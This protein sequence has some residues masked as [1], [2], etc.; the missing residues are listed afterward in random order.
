MGL[1]ARNGDTGL[2]QAVAPALPARRHYRI[3]AHEA[4][5]HQ[6]GIEQSHKPPNW[7]GEATL[8][9]PPAHEAA[10]LQGLN[11]EGYLGCQHIGGGLPWFEAAG[12]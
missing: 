2:M 4:Y 5:W 9:L 1:G 8:P 11:P 7:P 6:L 3:T 12:K 10:S